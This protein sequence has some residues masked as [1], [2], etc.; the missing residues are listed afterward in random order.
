VARTAS[1]LIMDQQQGRGHL[2]HF[3][4]PFFAHCRGTATASSKQSVISRLLFRTCLNCESHCAA[5]SVPQPPQDYHQ[6]RHAECG[7]GD[8]NE[9]APRLKVQREQQTAQ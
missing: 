2:G 1:R 9:N 7:D 3:L 6:H 4:S 8:G 5:L